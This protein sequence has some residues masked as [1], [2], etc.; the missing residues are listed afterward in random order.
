MPRGWIHTVHDKDKGVWRNEV[1]GGSAMLFDL[2][3]LARHWGKAGGGYR[4][5]FTIGIWG[6]FDASGRWKDRKYRLRLRAIDPRRTLFSGGLR[7][8]KDPE[9]RAQ[10]SRAQQS[11]PTA[12]GACHEAIQHREG[13]VEG[14]E[15]RSPPSSSWRPLRR[16]SLW[17]R[18]VVT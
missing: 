8:R 5:G 3:R 11:D 1:E 13:R 10:V 2:G 6:R 17:S 16:A 7:T 14:F 18:T 12:R 4:G 9:W 15:E